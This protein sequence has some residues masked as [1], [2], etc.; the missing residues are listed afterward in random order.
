MLESD[1]VRTVA[2]GGCSTE[3]DDPK[4]RRNSCLRGLLA[5][6]EMVALGNRLGKVLSFRALE[7]AKGAGVSKPFYTPWPAL[8]LSFLHSFIAH[9]RG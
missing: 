5:L 2:L 9:T 4:W 6:L 7:K 8:L 1:I 3:K